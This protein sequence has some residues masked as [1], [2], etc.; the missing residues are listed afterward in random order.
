[1]SRLH[2]V[3]IWLFAFLALSA[4]AGRDAHAAN[5][6]TTTINGSPSAINHGQSVTFTANISVLCID[7]SGGPGTNGG[8]VT[9]LDGGTT[10]GTVAVTN[11]GTDTGTATF[12]TTSLSVGQHTIT[13]NYSGESSCGTF[14]S[15]PISCASSSGTTTET[16]NATGPPADS[17]KL[18]TL[19][20][21]GAPVTANISAQ[22]VAGAVSGA[23]ND[24]FNNGGAFFTG[25]ANGFHLNFAGEPV[26]QQTRH[27]PRIDD[28]YAALGY[29][30]GMPTKAPPT[31]VP[32]WLPWIDVRGTGFDRND[33][34]AGIQERQ[35]NA[36]AGIGR[37]LSADLLVGV[38]SGY[39]DFHLDRCLAQRHNEW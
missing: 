20:I 4:L 3:A 17:L 16:V 24:A 5:P 23:I 32:V 38:F 33:A 34:A 2:S 13:A 8:T 1:M 29:A 21:S 27:D 18:Q 10:L 36:T 15:S 12:S 26:A 30:A 11:T 14:F 25:D 6:T 37:L 35:V 39:E 19:L 31:A 9:F 22:A 7:C 28:A